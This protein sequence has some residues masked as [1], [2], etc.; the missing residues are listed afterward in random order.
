MFA[1]RVRGYDALELLETV[2]TVMLVLGIEPGSFG[3]AASAPYC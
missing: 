3:K 1:Y 2:V